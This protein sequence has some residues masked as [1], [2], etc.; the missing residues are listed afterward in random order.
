MGQPPAPANHRPN[1]R[2]SGG[3]QYG[4][5]QP[6]PQIPAISP[7]VQDQMMMIMPHLDNIQQMEKSQ[8]DGLLMSLLQMVG[9]DIA[10][11]LG[12]Q[13]QGQGGKG[14]RGGQN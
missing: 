14:G 11:Q 7:Q 10:G 2:V 9:P 13:V 5:G 6:G 3:G 4:G 1:N 12:E 8:L